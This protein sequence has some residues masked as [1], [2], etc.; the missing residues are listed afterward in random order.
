MSRRYLVT[1][2]I[3]PNDPSRTQDV[4][5]EADSAY[6]AGWLY[7]QLQPTNKICSIR[8]APEHRQ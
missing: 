8:I 6:Q 7:K 3:D 5:I 1:I 4:S 2:R